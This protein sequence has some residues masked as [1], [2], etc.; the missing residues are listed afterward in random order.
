[1]IATPQVCDRDPAAGK[2]VA[3]ATRKGADRD[4]VVIDREFVAFGTDSPSRSRLI[5]TRDRNLSRLI[6]TRELAGSRSR[7][8]G[9]AIPTPRSPRFYS[10][11]EC[12]T[13]YEWDFKTSRSFA[14]S[15]PSFV[16][17]LGTEAGSGDEGYLLVYVCAAAGS[18]S[19]MPL[20]EVA[21][22]IS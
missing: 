6:A 14:T 1:M 4:K 12:P 19:G 16:P 10:D 11:R 13:Q 21:L 7:A 17:R 8:C 15:E 18:E 5:T 9:V 2:R 22:D 3:I 20:A